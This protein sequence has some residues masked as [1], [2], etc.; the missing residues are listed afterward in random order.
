MASAN[1]PE[2]WLIRHGETEWSLSGQ[3]TS[4]TDIPLTAAGEASAKELR[5]RLKDVRFEAVYVSP[6]QRAIETCRLAGFESTAMIDPNLREW[7]YG[8]Y[9]GKTTAEI[10]KEIPGWSVWTSPLP[11]GESL[12]SVGGRADAVIHTATQHSGKVALFAHA[13]ILR[14]LAA[15]W[16]GQAPGFGQHLSLGTG[17]MS[18]LGFE[19]EQRTISRWNCL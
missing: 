17:S 18:V 16:V 15:R 6:A 5:S 7:D 14:I 3:H 1:H 4:R 13:H 19:R 11:E 8:V 2:I 9:E 12:D 10:Q